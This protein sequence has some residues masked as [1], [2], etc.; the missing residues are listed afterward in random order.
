[1]QK[2]L[3]LPDHV[4]PLASAIRQKINLRQIDLIRQEFTTIGG[5]DELRCRE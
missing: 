3:R 5:H 4:M 1:M 2:L